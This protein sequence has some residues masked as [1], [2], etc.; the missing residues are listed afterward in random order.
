MNA[1]VSAR[2]HCPFVVDVG[3]AAP[4]FAAGPLAVARQAV[5][6]RLLVAEAQALAR[7]APV[8]AVVAA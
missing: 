7:R 2:A 5:A 6:M 4:R 1:P 3:R 8:Q